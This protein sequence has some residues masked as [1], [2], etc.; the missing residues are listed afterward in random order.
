MGWQ[1][2]MDTTER[3]GMTGGD[4]EFKFGRVKT[5]KQKMKGLVKCGPNKSI[6][7]KV[8]IHSLQHLSV[9]CMLEITSTGTQ[10]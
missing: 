6:F 8:Q 2:V 1:V 3:K 4:C 5:T 9:Y 10:Q 7:L